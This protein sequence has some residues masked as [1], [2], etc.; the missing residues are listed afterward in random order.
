MVTEGVVAVS[1]APDPSAGD[2]GR[3]VCHTEA[4]RFHALAVKAT[5]AGDPLKGIAWA[6]LA[7]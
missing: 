6:L 3:D 4:V 2:D 1:V 5:A 7:T